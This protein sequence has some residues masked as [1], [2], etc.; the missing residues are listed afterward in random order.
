ML[1]KKYIRLLNNL[2][3]TFVL[4]VKKTDDSLR[5]CVNYRDFNKIIIKNKYLL[6]LLFKTLDYFA[7][8]KHFTKINI[9]NVY[10]R[11]RI[12]KNNK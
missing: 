1:K 12:R 6:L 3:K 7:Y 5:L 4:F 2:T 8:K 9:R 11:I 10:Y